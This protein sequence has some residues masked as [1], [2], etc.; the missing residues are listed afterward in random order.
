MKDV[1]SPPRH[2]ECD[3]SVAVRGGGSTVMTRGCLPSRAVKPCTQQT[4]TERELRWECTGLGEGAVL[5]IRMLGFNRIPF[6][7]KFLSG[8]LAA[9]LCRP[10]CGMK[11]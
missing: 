9:V 7:G 2:N 1:R 6:M 3:T 5:P 4:H 10:A 11:V 8:E